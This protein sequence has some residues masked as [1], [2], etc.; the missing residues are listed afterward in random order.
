MVT[1]PLHPQEHVQRLLLAVTALAV[2]VLFLGKPLFLLWLH[3]GRSCFGV[4]RVSAA[5]RSSDLP[6]SL[7]PH[8]PYPARPA[9]RLQ[10][11]MPWESMTLTPAGP[12]VSDCSHVLLPSGPRP[13]REPV[14]RLPPQGCCSAGGGPRLAR[15]RVMFL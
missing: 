12:G 6:R 2:P 1:P 14:Q 8:G 13:P 10:A 5:H 15:A 4:S 7:V 3:N 9:R 11:T